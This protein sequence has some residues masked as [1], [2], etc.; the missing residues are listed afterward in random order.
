M[1]N[2]FCC[3]FS[4]L[5]W[6]FSSSTS[7]EWTA[8]CS[9]LCCSPKDRLSSSS[10]SKKRFSWAARSSFCLFSCSRRNWLTYLLGSP[11]VDS[12]YVHFLHVIRP[13]QLEVS[14]LRGQELFQIVDF[15]L[16]NFNWLYLNVELSLLRFNGLSVNWGF[17]AKNI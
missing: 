4:I 2:F 8:A 1:R 7:L 14:F 5:S 10:S 3:N 6:A 16:R 15:S 9:C 12:H 11:T 17:Q 13:L